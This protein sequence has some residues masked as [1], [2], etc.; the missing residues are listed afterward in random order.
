MKPTDN[1]QGDSTTC[2]KIPSGD[3]YRKVYVR[4]WSDERFLRLSPLPPSG[5]SLWLYLLTGPHTTSLP[6]LF[7]IGEASLAES[8]GW[9]TE[10]LR[11]AFAEA[12]RE[13]LAKASPKARLIWLP[14][15]LRYNE[16]ASPN[17][18]RSWRHNLALLPPCDVRDEAV[19]A[20]RDYCYERGKEWGKAFDEAWGKPYPKPCLKPSPKPCPNQEQEQDQ[21]AGA[22]GRSS[23]QEQEPDPEEQQ[24][25]NIYISDA[26]AKNRKKEA[27]VRSSDETR[28]TA[29]LVTKTACAEGA[30]RKQIVTLLEHFGAERIEAA[31]AEHA[32]P[33]MAPWEFGKIAAN[34][35]NGD[36]AHANGAAAPS[37]ETEANVDLLARLAAEKAKSE[38][39]KAEFDAWCAIP[40]NENKTRRDY[41][42]E[43]K[44]ANA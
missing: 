36:S 26:P 41:Y 23:R 13:G 7:Q 11:E 3:I 39:L 24:M 31:I 18:V 35:L 6:G 25:R 30:A 40:G 15:A 43:R 44:R 27:E 28:L 32:R 17:V 20:L 8:L 19:T 4:I 1:G 38:A 2:G 14:N 10:A 37:A 12:L 33:A 22:G 5:Q 34:F 9:S 42:D 29:L 16:P 21:Q